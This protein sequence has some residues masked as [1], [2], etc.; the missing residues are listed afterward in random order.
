MVKTLYSKTATR[1]GF[2]DYAVT[3]LCKPLTITELI[4]KAIVEEM[5]LKIDEVFSHCWYENPNKDESDIDCIKILLHAQT[6]AS[7]VA[8]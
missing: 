6:I 4:V 8:S 1:S 3:I 5:Q 2:T 7:Q